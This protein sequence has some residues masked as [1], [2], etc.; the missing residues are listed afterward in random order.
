MQAGIP[1]DSDEARAICAMLSAILTGRSVPAVGAD[2]QAARG[3]P[4]LSGP[5]REHAAGDPQPPRWRR[6]ARRGQRAVREPRSA[7]CR[8]TTTWCAAGER[9][10][11]NA[12]DISRARRVRVGRRAQRS[13]S[14]TATA[15]RRST[16]IAPTGTI[17]LLM[18]CDTTGVEPD[19]ALVKFKKLA[20][21]GYFKIA[22]ESVRPRAGGTGVQRGAGQGDHDVSAGH[23]DAGTC[24]CPRGLPASSARRFGAWLRA[25]ASRTTELDR[26]SS[27]CR[28]CSSSVRVHAWSVG[29]EALKALGATRCKA[30]ADMSFNLLKRLGPE[31]PEIDELNR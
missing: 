5:T 29:D 7:R 4:G 25:R 21:G 16:V 15:T 31:R 27:R 26:S 30:K 6:T 19:F 13:A 23:A 1:Y 11:A 28:A 18:D 17:G 12:R 20:G 22:N 8:S 9:G 10:I 3:V 24:R 14:S 2:G